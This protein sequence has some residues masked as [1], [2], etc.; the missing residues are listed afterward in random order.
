VGAARDEAKALAE[1]QRRQ[2][3][4]VATAMSEQ[5]KEL[6]GELTRIEQEQ[7]VRSKGRHVQMWGGARLAHA[8]VQHVCRR[9]LRAWRVVSP[10]GISH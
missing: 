8:H 6:E 2:A 5:R 1:E 9:G 4:E 3:V 7:E 10:A